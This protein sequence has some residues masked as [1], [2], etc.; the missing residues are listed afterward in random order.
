MASDSM[1]NA[2]E[3]QLRR[4][5]LSGQWFYHRHDVTEELRLDSNFN[6]PLNFMFGGFLPGR[7]LFVTPI[8]PPGNLA[9]GSASDFCRPAGIPSDVTTARLS[10]GA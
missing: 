3:T 6:S 8:S 5:L 10:L 7:Q 4:G 1:V 9:Y 2:L